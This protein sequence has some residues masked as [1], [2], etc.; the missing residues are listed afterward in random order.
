MCS[1]LCIRKTRTTTLHPQLDGQI[2]RMNKT[3]LDTLS[4]PCCEHPYDWDCLLPFAMAAYQSSTHTTTSKT[5]NQLILVTLLAP[6]PP[7]EQPRSTWVESLRQR[8][9]DTYRIVLSSMLRSHRAQKAGYDCKAKLYDFNDGDKVWIYDPKRRRGYTP[10]LDAK[11]LIGLFSAQRKLSGAVCL[12]K[13]EGA[14]KGRIVNVDRFFLFVVRDSYCM[15][16]IKKEEIIVAQYSTPQEIGMSNESV[17]DDVND[18]QTV[19]HYRRQVMLSIEDDSVDENTLN[20]N[21]SDDSLSPS[22]PTTVLPRATDVLPLKTRARRRA[23]HL[24]WIDDFL[25]D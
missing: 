19:A 20:H 18:I 25:A 6:P 16:T 3:L 15:S 12:I 11:R 1:L 14:V 4:K 24:V 7:N 2:E 10:K 5:P 21:Y 9:R 17:T 23:R 22:F 8:F 13:Q